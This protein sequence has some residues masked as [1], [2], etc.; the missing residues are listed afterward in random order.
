MV[1]G[2]FFAQQMVDPFTMETV[3]VDDLT[4]APIDPACISMYLGTAYGSGTTERPALLTRLFDIETQIGPKWNPMRTLN[5]NVVGLTAG[6][7]VQ[8]GATFNFGIEHDVT[9]QDLIANIR[10]GDILYTIIEAVGA[11][12]PGNTAYNYRIRQICP[13]YV[14]DVQRD[15]VEGVFCSKITADI[16]YATALGAAIIVEIDTDYATL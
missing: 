9:S 14:S 4:T 3:A 10:A 8:P 13:L 6:V 1:N 16:A 11:P 2:D 15:E 5:C 12:I 7:E